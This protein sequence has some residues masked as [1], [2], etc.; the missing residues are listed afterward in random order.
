MGTTYAITIVNPD[1]VST[2]SR[3]VEVDGAPSPDGEIELLDDG[4]EHV[5]RV[6]MGEVDSVAA[7]VGD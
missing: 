2:G 6:T 3:L 4:A 7:E 1:G 5:V